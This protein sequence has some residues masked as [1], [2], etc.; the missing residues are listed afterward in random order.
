[1]RNGKV[2]WTVLLKIMCQKTDETDFVLHDDEAVTVGVHRCLR[3]RRSAW[4]C[5]NCESA[6]CN[7]SSENALTTITG[8]GA[9]LETTYASDAN[10]LGTYVW[11]GALALLLVWILMAIRAT[12]LEE[13]RLREADKARIQ[14]V[15]ELYNTVA[16]HRSFPFDTSYVLGKWFP[17][18][19]DALNTEVATGSHSP[20]WDTPLYLILRADATVPQD[21]PPYM[22]LGPEYTVAKRLRKDFSAS[23]LLK[24]FDKIFSPGRRT[25]VSRSR[26]WIKQDLTL[27]AV[28]KEILLHAESWK[29]TTDK[30]VRRILS[31]ARKSMRRDGESASMDS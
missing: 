2:W 13:A 17:S 11:E 12:F 4:M 25:D 30:V 8:I 7:L 1:M 26:V 29:L 20:R 31:D 19:F 16:F 28:V 6:M 27:L 22:L 3:E 5:S 9:I 15:V 10:N 24:T 14:G 18:L 23:L 21:A